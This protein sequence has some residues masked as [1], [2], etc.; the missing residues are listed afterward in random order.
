MN[1]RINKIIAYV[2]AAILIVSLLAV[3]ALPVT[4]AWVDRNL[5]W[6]LLYFTYPLA[7]IAVSAMFGVIRSEKEAKNHENR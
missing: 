1:E 3:T 4:L 5:Y 6:L 7:L 2:L